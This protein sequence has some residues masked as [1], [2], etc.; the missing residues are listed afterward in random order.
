MLP[1]ARIL[2]TTRLLLRPLTDADADALADLR[3]S[4]A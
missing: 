3:V 1:D 4:L 2:H